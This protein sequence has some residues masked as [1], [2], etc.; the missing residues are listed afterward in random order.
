MIWIGKT[1][2]STIILRYTKF[3]VALNQVAEQTGQCHQKIET[4]KSPVNF[5]LIKMFLI[6]HFESASKRN[7]AWTRE[8]ADPADLHTHIGTV[9]QKRLFVMPSIGVALAPVNVIKAFVGEIVNFKSAGVA[10]LHERNPRTNENVR[11]FFERCF[12]YVDSNLY[13]P[14]LENCGG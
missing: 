10:V 13:L 11:I 12:T 2:L 1:L 7:G 6:K 8:R 4:A 9:F 3:T 5:E 14:N